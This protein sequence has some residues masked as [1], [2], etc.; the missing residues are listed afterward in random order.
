MTFLFAMLAC[1]GTWRA[2]VVTTAGDELVLVEPEG[3]TSGLRGGS[4]MEVLQALTGCGVEVRGPRLAGGVVVRDWRVTDAGDG[5]PPYVGVLRRYGG[6]W[7]VD[8]RNSGQPVILEYTTVGALTEAE[9]QLVLVQGLV[10]GAQTV[11]VMGYRV[12][13]APDPG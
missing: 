12:L 1:A 5:Q 13:G 8:D 4:S 3:R 9:G 2:G 7:I 11:R 10:V 6:N